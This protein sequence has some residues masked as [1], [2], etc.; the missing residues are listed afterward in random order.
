LSTSFF[1]A[2]QDV[3]VDAY[4][5]EDLTNEELPIGSAAYMWGYR[6]GMVLISGGGLMLADRLGWTVVFQGAAMIM[7]LGPI[8][9][10]YS[11]EPSIIQ[12]K[13]K[14]LQESVIGPLTEFFRRPNPWLLLAFVFS[15][16]LG[17]QMI[18]SLNTAFFMEAGY[19]KFEIGVVAKGYGLAATLTGVWLAGLLM[20]KKSIIYCLWFFGWLQ[21]VNNA[22]LTALWLLPAKMSYLTFFISLDH[23]SVGA[24][25]AA[26]VTFLS[27][28]TNV[29]YTATQYALLT[30]LMS[31]PRSFVGS[32]AGYL[33]EHLGWPGFYLLGALLTLPGLYLLKLLDRRGLKPLS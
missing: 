19:T 29:S 3:V 20:K 7:I 6:L 5:R 8:T 33:V 12:Q 2:T 22:S 15:Y 24:G 32:P 4:R 21:L 17:E 11:P 18:T 23:L 1:S 27:S 26:F 30:S 28:Q 16:K 25:A 31:I 9:L 14:T 13:P 10:L